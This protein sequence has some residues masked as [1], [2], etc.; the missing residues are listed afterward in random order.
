VSVESADMKQQPV[1]EEPAYE[2]PSVRDYGTVKE[3]TLSNIQGRA[4]DIPKGDPL[5]IFS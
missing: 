5:H 4:S 3:L 2:K 1:D